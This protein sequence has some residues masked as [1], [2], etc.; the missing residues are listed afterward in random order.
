MQKP[1]DFNSS[2]GIPSLSCDFPFNHTGK[3]RFGGER[4]TAGKIKPGAKTG[5][6]V[7]HSRKG[8]GERK[9]FPGL[10]KTYWRD[11]QNDATK[12]GKKKSPKKTRQG[13]V[14]MVNSG[15]SV[16]RIL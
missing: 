3:E 14:E 13:K 7:E 6:E 4:G 2:L 5:R 9:R 15:E 16:E 10:D 11:K 8:N 12:R 1:R